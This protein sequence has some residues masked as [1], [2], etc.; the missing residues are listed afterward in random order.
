[1]NFLIP[2]AAFLVAIGIL[3]AVHEYGHFIAA[4]LLGVKVLR[5]SIGFGRPLWLRRAGPDRTEYCVSAVPFGGYV[6]LLDERDCPVALAEQHRAFNRQ[7]IP[8]RIAILAA[9]PLLNFLFAIVA[10]WAMFMIGVPGVRP[11]IGDIA[12]DSIAARAGLRGGDQIV[13]VGG[14]PTAT[15]EGA[16]VAILDEM[17]DSGRI[18][19]IVRGQN[20]PDRAAT[21]DTTGHASSLTEPGQLFIG[22]GIQPWTPPAVL[23][24]ITP[25]G[26][27]ERAGLKPGD[28][29]VSADGETIGSWP[30]WVRFVRQRPGKTIEVF[31][32]RGGG[33]LRVALDVERAETPEGVIGR[34]GAG[35]QL[36]EEVY[37]RYPVVTAMGESLHRTWEMASLTVRMVARMITGDVSVRNISGPINIA[38]YAGY[39]ASVGIAAF[40]SF[41]AVVSISLGILNLLPVPMLDGGQIAYQVAEAAKGSPLSERAQ[42][43]GQQVGIFLL[44]MLMSFAFYNDISRLL[45]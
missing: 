15:W 35:A 17:L 40:L 10:Y 20:G 45:G 9:G 14:R 5:Y 21:L 32:E 7:P 31:L 33:R 27:A 3:V 39:S 43:I 42:L 22:L 2:A 37:E 44:L 13:S 12:P 25:G 1:M 41:L 30:E 8:A 26:T 6:K 29:I 19:L 24:T 34:I 38:Q 36:P 11:L 23:G 16:I 18:A 28:R 4:R